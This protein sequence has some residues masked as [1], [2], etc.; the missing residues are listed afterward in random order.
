MPHTKHSLLKLSK[1][2]LARIVLDYQGKFNS[3]LQSSKDDVC[4]MNSKFNGLGSELHAS[5]NVP[6]NLTKYIKTMDRNYQAFLAITKIAL[7]KKMF[8]EVNVL[9][10]PSNVE[11]CHCLKSNN[12]A[13]Q[14]V[15]IKL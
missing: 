12:N 6:D 4:E 13:T 2:E 9:I 11:D 10:D 15:I 14:K 5:K 3:I 1:D 7:L 8:S